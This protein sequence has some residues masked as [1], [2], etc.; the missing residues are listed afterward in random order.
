M[1]TVFPTAQGFSGS[2][3]VGERRNPM[4]ASSQRLGVFVLKREYTIENSELLPADV[5][6]GILLKDVTQPADFDELPTPEFV[7]TLHESDLSVF[8]PEPDIIVLGYRQVDSS[9]TLRVTEPGGSP[10]LW[11]ERNIGAGSASNINLE[12][13]D[14]E[15]A[16][17]DANTNLFGWQPR[18]ISPRKTD[19]TITTTPS[20]PDEL[21]NSSYEDVIFSWSSFNNRFFNAYRRDFY[22]RGGIEN[23]IA[24]GAVVDIERSYPLNDASPTTNH[25][26]F[27]LENLQV[28]AKI[29]LH[30]G[31][32][33]DK[34][35]R[36]CCKSI[37]D[38]HLDTLIIKPDFNMAAV[39]WRGVWDFNLY[40]IESYRQLEV[41]A[42]VLN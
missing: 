20:D 11:Y 41:K 38:I 31:R 42:E 17:L 4:S 6:E 39:L 8:K 9:N 14:E 22:K 33:A 13:D 1:K 15:I 29:F 16:D 5:V 23:E 10:L 35:G 26:L 34:P 12:L 7:Y 3:I 18:Q 30:D 19:G 27:T 21:R 2:Y 28:S 25:Y 37:P 24:S 36:W 40:P 32:G